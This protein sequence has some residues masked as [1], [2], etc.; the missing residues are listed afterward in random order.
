DR[1]V[2]QVVGEPI[3]RAQLGA[4]RQHLPQRH[5]VTSG[6][7]NHSRARVCTALSTSF[8]VRPDAS[9][10]APDSL[11]TS[12]AT[13]SRDQRV[14]FGSRQ[15]PHAS[16]TPC[17]SRAS[18]TINTTNSCTDE[19]TDGSTC[20]AVFVPAVRCFSPLALNIS[21]SKRSVGGAAPSTL[22]G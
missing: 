3:G 15:P 7:R 14:P 9:S 18:V 13:H 17:R 10:S 5:D 6:R 11:R 12:A 8:Q 22:T 19:T 16:V 1:L 4:A 21:C 20:T 2:H